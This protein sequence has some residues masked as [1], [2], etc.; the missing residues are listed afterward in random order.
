MKKIVFLILFILAGCFC[1]TAQWAPTNYA[2]PMT[3]YGIHF[4]NESVGYVCGYHQVYK[5]SDGGQNWSEVC[6]DVFVNGPN[7][8]WFMNESI[9]F[10]VGASSSSEPKVGKTINGGSSWTTATLPTTGGGFATPSRIY[11]FDETTGYIVCRDGLMYKT[12]NQGATWDKLTLGTTEDLSSVHFP[13]ALVGYVSI[14]W[15]STT[16]LKTINGGNSWTP[17]NLGQT[18]GVKDVF[19]TTRD[20]G[21]LACSNSTIMKTTNGGN[22][23]T[24]FNLGTSDIFYT[25]VFTSRNIGYAAGSAGT[26][27]TTTNHGATWVPRVSG[28][29]DILFRMD[30]PSKEVGYIGTYGPPASVI[31]TTNGGG[32]LA[33]PEERTEQGI[34]ISPNPTS[35][36][37]IITMDTK[38]TNT[39][40]ELLDMTGKTVLQQPV[41]I[42]KRIS[43]QLLPNGVYIY[44]VTGDGTIVSTG[45][46]VK[47]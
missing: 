45:K 30:F 23:W 37:I 22:S 4:L 15:S 10:I 14:E 34:R 7:G 26:L 6:R 27:V 28:A 43:I 1:A 47:Q 38:F 19:F 46:L 42:N 25:I 16:I 12:I 5:T 9:G 32:I 11:F 41:S 18:I 24:E 2:E 44:K 35:E 13:T 39:Q 21:Y 31:K 40:L 17:K 20:T 29:S 8:V 33:V 36:F 3:V